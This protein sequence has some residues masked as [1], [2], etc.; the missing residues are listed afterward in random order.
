[1]GTVIKKSSGYILHIKGASEIVLSKCAYFINEHGSSE[2]LDESKKNDLVKNVI[3]KMACDGLRTICVAYR[4]FVSFDRTDEYN[5]QNIQYYNDNLDW[6]N[7]KEII[8]KLTCLCLIGIEDPVRDE[9]PDAIK[10]CQ[11]SGVIVRFEQTLYKKQF[12]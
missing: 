7:E 10:K 11:T 3:E 4:E 9:V 2:I 6:S 1:M 8:D 12:L 5:D